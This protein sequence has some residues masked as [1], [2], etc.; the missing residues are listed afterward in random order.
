MAKKRKFF[1]PSQK[2]LIIKKHLVDHT[3]LS[4]LCDQHSLY[5]TA[6]Y[7]WQKTFFENGTKAFDKSKGTEARLKKQIDTLEKKLVKKHEVLSDL[8]EE[9]VALKKYWG[10]LTASWI[11][12]NTETLSS[13]LSNIGAIKPIFR[14]PDL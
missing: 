7:R 5:P 11:P 4:D 13:I 2:V 12:L 8:M 14:Q 3:P 6:F 1:T 10:T 9:H